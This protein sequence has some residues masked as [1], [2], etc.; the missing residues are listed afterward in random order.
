[1]PPTRVLLLRHGQSEWNAAGRWQGQADPPLSELGLHQAAVAATKVGAVDA[2]VSSDLQRASVTADVF[3]EALGIGPVIIE[4]GLRERDA[5]E[6]SGHTRAEIEEA[7]PGWLADGR[8]PPSWEADAQLLDRVLTALTRV[9][10]LAPGGDVL[11]I[12]H[13]GVVYT[14]EAHLGLDHGGYLANVGGRW[15]DVEGD[16]VTARDRIV[17]VDGDDAAVTIPRVI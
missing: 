1:M 14:L 8:R 16:T 7:W 10:A 3:A 11:A 4:P 5:G 17:L 13:G 6:W 9:A 2:I 12:T 15:L